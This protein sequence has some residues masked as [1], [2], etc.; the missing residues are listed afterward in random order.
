V[1]EAVRAAENRFQRGQ[2]LE[3]IYAPEE[4]TFLPPLTPGKIM[5]VGRNYGE[6]VAEVGGVASPRPSGFVKLV[7]C[8]TAHGQPIL[9]PP[10]TTKL[11]YENELAVVMAVDCVDIPAE[12]AY[13]YVFGYTI[14]NDVSAREVQTEESQR[15]NIIMGKNF[16]TSAPL[17]PWVVT[18]DEIPDPHSLRILTRVNGQVRQNS[19]TKD[20]IHKIPAQ[21]AWYSHAGLQAGDV[22]S[23][24]TPSGV[25]LGYKGPGSW[26]LKKGD[27][28]ECEV[29]KIG[30][31]RNPVRDRSE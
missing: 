3:G 17:G 4:I 2:H 20:Q 19:N 8:L 27:V 29:E 11:D 13:D 10:W 28:V 16:P 7:S 30:V 1:A 24:G 12:R 23:T 22:V 25:A 9:R 18:K 21:L 14:M 15:G 31:L 6:H 26:F 5:A